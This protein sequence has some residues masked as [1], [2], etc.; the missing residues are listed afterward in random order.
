MRVIVV[1][2]CDSSGLTVVSQ[3]YHFCHHDG[4]QDTFHCGYGTVFNEY[5]GTC[6]YKNNVDCQAGEGY[7]PETS[8]YHPPEPH[9]Q[10]E[11][12]GYNPPQLDYRPQKK[13]QYYDEPSFQKPQFSNQ[14]NFN[15]E[16]KPFTNFNPF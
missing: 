10:H 6:D 15:D 5:I 9:Y 8:G 1:V 7:S 12:P 4:K 11:T 16:I 13:P 2:Q 3:V 14:F